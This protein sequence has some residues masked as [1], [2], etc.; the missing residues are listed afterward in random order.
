MKAFLVKH[1]KRIIIL[2]ADLTCLIAAL[3]AGPLSGALLAKTDKTCFWTLMGGQ[4]PTCGGTHFVNDLLSGRIAAAFAD[5]QLLF[6]VTVYAAV[7]LVFL[8]L[9]LLFGLGFAKKILGWMYNIP[10][11]IAWGVILIAFML[12][13]NLPAIFNML[14]QLSTVS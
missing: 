12:W 11:L 4:C 1:Y 3:I 6:A 10:T 13:R 5:N 9:W 2:A 7:S 8:N 14:S